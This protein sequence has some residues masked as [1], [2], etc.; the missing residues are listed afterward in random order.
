M[1]ALKTASLKKVFVPYI[2]LANLDPRAALHEGN[3]P[4]I[5]SGLQLY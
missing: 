1:R 4:G 2:F 3:D 5:E